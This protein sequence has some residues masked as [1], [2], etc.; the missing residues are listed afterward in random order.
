MGTTS[1]V[2]IRRPQRWDQPFDPDMLE[3]D[4][5]WL[6]SLPPFSEMDKSAFPANTPLDGVLRNDC[7]IRKV[8][9]GE[10]I[11]REGD[12]GNSAFLVLAGSVRVVLGQLP[13]QSLGRTTAKQKSWFSAISALWKQP[14]FPEVRTVDQITPGG[15]SRVQ[16]HGDTASIF[17]QDFDGVVTHERTLQ[18]G[19]GEMFGE[20]A[21][22][23]RA[24][25]TATVVADSHATLVEVRWQGLRLLRRD[26]VLAQQLEQNYRTNWLMIHLRE[27]PLFRF[28]PE[29]CLQKV[30]DAT[31]LRSFGRLEWHS[32]Y[33]RTRKLKPV[34]Q[35]ESEPLVAM[36]G[37]LPTDLLLI[38]SGFARVCSRYGEGHRTLAYLGKGHMFGLR[39]IVHNT[40]RDSNQAPVT[41]QESLRAV[42]FVDTL[43]IPIEVVAEYVLPYIRRTELPDPISR[44]DQQARARHDIASQVPTGMLE[45]IVQERL[46]NGRQAMVIDLNACTR[47]DDCVKACATTHDG[48]PRFTRSGPTNDG[49]QFT[50]ACMHCADPV[51]MI[52]CPTG[53]ISRH[54]ETGTVSVHENICIGCGTCAASCPYENIQMR[55]MRDPKGRMYF[56]ESAGLP[57]MK[58]TKCDLCQSQPSGPAC[59][60]ACPHDALVRIDLGN[61]EDLSD[62]ISQ[63]R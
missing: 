17:L 63:R 35:I 39:E 14:Q 31:L 42:G 46:N 20:V 22:M 61:L 15:S 4:V 56:D 55:T 54:S 33:R 21:A 44:D 9:P 45:F 10:V 48:N 47:C 5:Q 30:A 43:H 18:I 38:R 36:E 37:H 12:Y 28:L 58:A 25:R 62:W 60:N 50:Q 32:D 49:I 7:R 52:G 51:C 16:Q 11:V 8:Q 27:T 23:Y 1:T 2:E 53:A 34:E 6:S 29:N 24:P 26:R 40:Y 3:R 13:P 41:L 57:I 59:Q 19:P